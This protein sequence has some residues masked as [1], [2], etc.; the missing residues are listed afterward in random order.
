MW[1]YKNWSKLNLQ[2]IKTVQKMFSMEI[3]RE[4]T[5][6]NFACVTDKYSGKTI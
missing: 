4:E 2:N 6:K 3:Q 1:D 5:W